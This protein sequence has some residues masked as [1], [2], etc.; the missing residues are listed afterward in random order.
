M[1][2]KTEWKNEFK[3]IKKTLSSFD[4]DISKLFPFLQTTTLKN[5]LLALYSTEEKL[6]F[7]RSKEREDLFVNLSNLR[8]E[9]RNFKEKVKYFDKSEENLHRIEEITLGL[10][11]KIEDFQTKQMKI[12]DDLTNE[13]EK[14][15]TDLDIFSN[16]LENYENNVKLCENQQ[17]KTQKFH[18]TQAIK[19]EGSDID[20][21]NDNI[22]NNSSFQS[23]KENFDGN[24]DKDSH[25]EVN[26]I[27]AL[28]EEIE[29][30]KKSIGQVDRNI[31]NNGGISCNWPDEDHKDFLKLRTRH[32]N[33]INKAVFL[34]ECLSAFPLYT[35]DNIKEHINKFQCFCELENEKKEFLENYRLLKEDRK[36]RLIK[37]IDAE[38]AENEEKY[39]EDEKSKEIEREKQEKLK[40]QLKQWKIKKI[41][42]KE[43][44]IE[45]KTQEELELKKQ[46]E[47]KFL[48]KKSNISEKLKEFKENK[49]I[50]KL[51]KIEQQKL[52]AKKI[53]DPA[54]I[55]RIRLKEEQILVKRKLIIEKKKNQELLKKIKQEKLL[56][57]KNV[58]FGY[59][60][61]KL[62]EETKAIQG[63][64]TE[65]F[66]TKKGD[67][68]RIADTFGGM[69]GK[70][71]SRAIPTWRQGV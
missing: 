63:K 68:P 8:K 54:E 12:F 22:H 62:N 65:K 1:S 71:P 30:I 45:R 50:E 59:V 18:S 5:E 37:E 4:P 36:K 44:E 11:G 29:K 60:E 9:V 13:E 58:K 34:E 33:N 15:L 56:E 17:K 57:S 41:S 39:K 47:I 52:N 3:K 26:E 2:E 32:K 43:L 35:K 66:D 70:G 31:R 48:R 69:L 6:D 14:Y 40:I 55:E 64:K 38:Q 16:R 53:L 61:S 21:N 49:E 28:D 27:E 51:Q 20:D 7:D 46:Q 42:K 10:E 19:E 25:S 67:Q 23:N 24:N